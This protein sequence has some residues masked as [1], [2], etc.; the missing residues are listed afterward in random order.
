MAAFPD[1]WITS[2]Q[3]SR[4]GQSAYLFDVSRSDA[5]FSERDEEEVREGARERLN[6]AAKVRFRVCSLRNLVSPL[7]RTACFY[8]CIS[9]SSPDSGSYPWTLSL[10]TLCYG[11]GRVSPVLIIILYAM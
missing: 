3:V 1:G 9:D 5:R 10:S 2:G 4:E 11:P 7:R 6:A 8:L